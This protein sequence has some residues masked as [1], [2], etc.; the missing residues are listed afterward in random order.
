M[1]KVASFTTYHRPWAVYEFPWG[2]AVKHEPSNKWHTV[3]LSP[4][5]QEID[6]EHLNIVLHSDGIEFI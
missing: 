5:A 2:T 1:K 6:V 4:D 3:I